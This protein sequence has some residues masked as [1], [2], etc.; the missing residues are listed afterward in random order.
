[1]DIEAKISCLHKFNK[2]E[3]DM[4]Q[5]N[6]PEVGQFKRD[7]EKYIIKLKDIQEIRKEYES[8]GH[9]HKI[10]DLNTKE[11]NVTLVFYLE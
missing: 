2:M 10:C 1:M 8:L 5:I 3:I 11:T 6:T 7:F 4:I 9:S